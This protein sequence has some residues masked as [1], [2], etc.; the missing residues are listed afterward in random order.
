MIPLPTAGAEKNLI[1]SR[2]IEFGVQTEG[3]RKPLGVVV[4]LSKYG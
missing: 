3:E 1:G 2:N 4:E